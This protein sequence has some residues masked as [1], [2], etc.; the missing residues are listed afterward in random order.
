VVTRQRPSQPP[1]PAP[2]NN[3][4]LMLPRLGSSARDIR[5]VYEEEKRRGRRRAV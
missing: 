5:D 4:L 1:P 3:V 2:A